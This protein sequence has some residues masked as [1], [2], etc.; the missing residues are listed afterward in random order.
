MPDTLSPS[1]GG[2][3]NRIIK[4]GCYRQGKFIASS[5]KELTDYID[6]RPLILST[7]YCCHI[8][9]ELIPLLERPDKIYLKSDDLLCGVVTSGLA[10]T[11]SLLHR[12]SVTSVS[13]SMIYCRT[14]DR[15]HGS[16]RAI[17]GQYKLGQNVI[18]LDDVATTGRSILKVARILIE[19][20]LQVRSAL[21]VVDREE[22]ATEYLASYDI[23]LYSVLTKSQITA[24]ANV[25][26][27]K[28]TEKSSPIIM[29]HK[30]PPRERYLDEY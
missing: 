15:T 24:V 6:L 13:A 12:L 2:L 19:H 10:M 9:C 27:T 21:V 23:K 8:L 18:I 14:E 11:G 25:G 16:L 26:E 20:G 1:L 29:Q 22:G 3:I 28:A 30:I 7:K 17:E 5:G 4:E